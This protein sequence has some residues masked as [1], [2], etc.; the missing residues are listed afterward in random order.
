MDK[1]K[2]LMIPG[3]SPVHPRILN[4]LSLPTV[5]HVGPEHVEELK[6][7]LDNLKKVVFCKD[8]E[9]FIV[10]GA[11]TLAREMAR[12]NIIA[13]GEKL[14]VLSQGFFGQSHDN[15]YKIIH[16]RQLILGL[17]VILTYYL[18]EWMNFCFLKTPKRLI[19]LLFHKFL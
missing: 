6:K 13:K 12:L 8:G 10:A 14:L 16:K 7:A 3:P 17:T 4:C 1:E 2:L 9:P 18:R 11:G 19:K 5:S 15:P